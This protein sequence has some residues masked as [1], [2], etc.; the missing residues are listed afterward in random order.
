MNSD[1]GDGPAVYELTLAGGLGAVFR[2]ALR[3]HDVTRSDV[4]TVLRAG[5][6]GE[7]LVDLVRE[8]HARGL[9]VEDVFALE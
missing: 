6:E 3:P 1:D 5:A 8:L 9:N 4:C 7:D 2:S